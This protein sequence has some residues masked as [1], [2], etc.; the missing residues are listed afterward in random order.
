MKKI[1]HR[2]YSDSQSN[3]KSK[4]KTLRLFA[5]FAVQEKRENTCLV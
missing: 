1:N 5:S 4:V 3:D 2:E